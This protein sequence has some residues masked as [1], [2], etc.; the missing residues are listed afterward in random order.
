MVIAFI[1]GGV[2]GLF[3]FRRF[4]RP[5]LHEDLVLPVLDDLGE[6]PGCF[7]CDHCGAPAA[8]QL[9]DLR[10]PNGVL[11]CWG[12]ALLVDWPIISWQR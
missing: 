9:D 12:C 8:L 1:L 5:Q 4:I 2:F 7:C 10:H 11:S 3:L 6:D